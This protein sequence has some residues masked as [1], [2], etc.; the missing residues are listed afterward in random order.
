MK[1]L[2]KF[3]GGVFQV[4]RDRP[5]AKGYAR[6]F[7]S[8]DEKLFRDLNAKG[9]GIYF[10]VNGFSA[11]IEQRNEL[12]LRL[13][14]KEP[15][16]NMPTARRTEF[17]T[18]INAVYADLDVKKE[19]GPGDADAM[20]H[21]LLLALKNDCFSPN[22]IIIT[23]NGLQPIWYVHTKGIGEEVQRLY[24][25]V[26]NGIIEWSKPHGGVGDKVNDVTR[27]LRLPTYNHNKSE[28]YKCEA[29]SIS[30]FSTSLI[31]M[32]GHFPY[33]EEKPK[34]KYVANTSYKRGDILMAIDKIEFQELIIRAFATV[35]RTASF[36]TQKRLVLDGRLTGTH[37]GKVNNGDFLA[38]SSHEPYEGN[39]ITAVASIMSCTTKEAFTWIKESYSLDMGKLKI[40]RVAK[41][42]SGKI[43]EFN[44]KKNE[45]VSQFTPYTW[46]TPGLD[47]C[48]WAMKKYQFCVI[49]GETSGG[50]TA[51][52]YHLAKE[53]AKL[54]HKVL[55]MSLEMSTQAMIEREALVYS[56]TTI[57]EDR[58][59]KRPAY[60]QK[61]YDN[62]IKELESITNLDLIGFP[63]EAS[64]TIET[65]FELVKERPGVDLIII[66]NLDKV[67]SPE[68]IKAFGRVEHICNEII[69]FTKEENIPVILLH[70]YNQ[71]QSGK[72]RG[73]E[74]LR[75]STKVGHDADVI[76]FLDRN[77]EKDAE[78]IDKA[79]L[80]IKAQKIRR[81]GDFCLGE[82]F[83]N[84][85][86]FTDTFTPPPGK[87]YESTEFWN[88]K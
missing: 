24:K 70:H 39:R 22:L 61:L 14:A 74:S 62:K 87:G 33:E 57:E 29:I 72:D 12:W 73:V 41:E 64:K 42:N 7:E 15:K 85:G 88:D 78:R 31:G 82:V 5:G 53:N 86:D 65:V 34:A 67:E 38:S 69:G 40:K 37:Q 45:V 66:D 56:G 63:R 1:F 8:Y 59:E 19:G 13:K 60:K 9:C 75:G 76:L 48:I 54:G 77:M 20:K 46:G 21:K 79:R 80:T 11:T 6:V 83:F 26:I 32:A 55:F 10:T 35:G 52:A 25:Q 71:R 4:F 47:S 30:G 17:L 51:F 23:K 68:G 36:D 2:E 58:L 50:K 28:P 81:T 27:V 43:T 49:A 16:T 18:N 3:P 84:R 44:N